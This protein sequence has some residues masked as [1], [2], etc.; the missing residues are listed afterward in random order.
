M[1]SSEQRSEELDGFGFV[2]SDTFLLNDEQFMRSSTTKDQALSGKNAFDITP[3]LGR[4]SNK[5]LKSINEQGELRDGGNTVFNRRHSPSMPSSDNRR[6]STKSKRS[7]RKLPVEEEGTIWSFLHDAFGAEAEEVDDEVSVAIDELASI[8]PEMSSLERFIK[9]L[10]SDHHSERISCSQ[11]TPTTVASSNTTESPAFH[12]RMP[13]DEEKRKLVP[14]ERSGSVQSDRSNASSNELNPTRSKAET[15]RHRRKARMSRRNEMNGVESRLVANKSSPS[16]YNSDDGLRAREERL[17]NYNMVSERIHA[18]ATCKGEMTTAPNIVSRNE[19]KKVF[20]ST[21]TRRKEISTSKLRRDQKYE[22]TVEEFESGGS[23]NDASLRFLKSTGMNYLKPGQLDHSKN[24]PKPYLEQGSQLDVNIDDS[25][26]SC[27][28]A[29]SSS[30]DVENDSLSAT[31]YERTYW[32][33]KEVGCRTC[34]PIRCNICNVKVTT[35]SVNSFVMGNLNCGCRNKSEQMVKDYLS[36]EFEVIEA[37]FDWCTN[38]TTG[39]ELPFDMQLK[40]KDII[41]EVDGEQHFNPD[42]YFSKTKAYK[43]ARFRDRIKEHHAMNK[44][45]GV[46]RILQTDVW[47]DVPGWRQRLMDAIDY[48]AVNK[49]CVKFL[50]KE[51]V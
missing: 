47:N 46:I 2:T 11:R 29:Y 49:P 45:Y 48:V 51:V 23:R 28:S 43:E 34:V 14:L 6:G 38:P 32:E 44:G 20:S 18:D 35:T 19:P 1:D 36:N 37:T 5:S 12:E 42:H 22:N 24:K 31:D 21:Q 15:T 3:P 10:D 26:S 7:D 8:H 9:K 25:S 39:R 16:T 27:R 33:E 13:S 4:K 41:I 30:Q 50:Y 17:Y 40:G